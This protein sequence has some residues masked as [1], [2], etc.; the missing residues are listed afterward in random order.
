ME[1]K[2]NIQGKHVLFPGRRKN[3]VKHSHVELSRSHSACGSAQ[4][5]AC[6]HI[7]PFAISESLETGFQ[8]EN[9][10]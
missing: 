10:T 8:G 6:V 4:L 1:N 7:A 5:P 2:P 3:P 9:Y